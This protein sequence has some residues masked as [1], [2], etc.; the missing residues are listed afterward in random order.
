MIRSAESAAWAVAWRP[1][2]WSQQPTWPHISHNRRWTQSS[3]PI[4]RQSS[5]PHECG[6]GLVICSM[7]VRESAIGPFYP[8]T[9]SYAAAATLPAVCG[10]FVAAPTRDLLVGWF[11][12]GARADGEPLRP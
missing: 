2:E 11:G 5:Q 6:S 1:G 10:R 12:V 7:W 4:A 9:E 8:R 3:R